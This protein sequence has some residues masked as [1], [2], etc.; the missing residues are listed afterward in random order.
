MYIC[1]LCINMH[2]HILFRLGGRGASTDCKLAPMAPVWLGTYCGHYVVFVFDVL[3]VVVVLEVLL[4]CPGG[5]AWCCS[6]ESP[7]T[8]RI[9]EA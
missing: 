6:S 4:G 9:H 1:K 8:W 3:L 2:T 7:V 5:A